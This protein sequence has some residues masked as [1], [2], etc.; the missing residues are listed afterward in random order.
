MHPEGNHSALKREETLT[1]A[2]CRLSLEDTTLCPTRSADCAGGA[3]RRCGGW[4]EPGGAAG[5]DGAAELDGDD[6]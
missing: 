1:L 2:P 4:A 5:A 6:G 3:G